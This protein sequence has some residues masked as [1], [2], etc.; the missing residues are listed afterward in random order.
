MQNVLCP[1]LRYRN[2]GSFKMFHFESLWVL[3][4][5]Q[6]SVPWGILYIGTHS[7]QNI[8]TFYILSYRTR[9]SMG[10]NF[11]LN[12]LSSMFLDIAHFET[13]TTMYARIQSSG[14]RGISKAGFDPYLKNSMPPSPPDKTI[15]WLQP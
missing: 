15:C 7:P 10:P 3:K 11:N 6:M 13:T 12:Y 14:I 4:Y 5:L 9:Y 8:S 2:S 1:Y